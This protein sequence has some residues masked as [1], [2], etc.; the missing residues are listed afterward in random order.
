MI[1]KH[2]KLAAVAAGLLAA[3]GA[4]GIIASASAADGADI[5]PANAGPTDPGTNAQL[6]DAID[7]TRDVNGDLQI[8]QAD[9]TTN[10]DG[11]AAPTHAD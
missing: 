4:A 6:P 10:A 9:P 8:T 7:I 5:A 3:G 11:Q 2:P 1:L